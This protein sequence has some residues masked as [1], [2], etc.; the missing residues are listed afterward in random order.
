MRPT[1]T[2]TTA[3]VT[4]TPTPRP[5]STPTATSSPEPEPIA[6]EGGQS[7]GDARAPELGNTGYD[8]QSYLLALTV[9]PDEQSIHGT[10]T[11]EAVATLAHLGRL[12]LDFIG[13]EIEHL[14]VDGVEAPFQRHDNKLIVDLPRPLGLGETF[15][16]AVTYGGQPQ[17]WPSPY[18]SFIPLG[19]HFT[20]DAIYAMA[21]PDG[22]RTWFPC[23][24]HPRDKA[25]FRYEITVPQG[26]VVA[27]NGLPQ[28]TIDGESTTTFW[29]QHGSPMATYLATIAVGHFQIIEGTA[30]SGIPLWHYV[31]AELLAPAQ[32][33]LGRTG[34]MIGFLESFF[35]PYP[36]ESYGHAVVP[37]N[38]VSMETQTLTL[39]DAGVVSSGAEW[40]MVHELAHQWFGDSVGPASWSDIWLNEGFAVY[41]SWLWAEAHSPDDL[42]WQLDA[43]EAQAPNADP[44]EPLADP[45]ADQLFG[46]NSYIKGA[47]VL[48]MLQHQIGD[49]LFFDVLRAYHE[50][51]EGGVASTDDLKTIV[52]EISGQELDW[53][54]EQWVYGT[55]MPEL[56]VN[57]QQLPDN[58]LSV[59]ICQR[60]PAP[61]L[62]P[63]SLLSTDQSANSAVE[64]IVVDQVD[65]RFSWSLPFAAQSVQVDPQQHLLA[66]VTVQ[67]AEVFVDCP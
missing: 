1:P 62:F 44:G 45:S 2:G 31:P 33:L 56:I 65:E 4:P 23:N 9:E 35:G 13:L 10:T 38:G 26:Y 50:R 51:F 37:M 16:I 32:E 22:A 42:R 29:W 34:E 15:Y 55:G 20:Q 24:D 61:F 5:S 59:Q 43:A 27:A 7:I 30:A 57:W 49:E 12:S 67:Q 46:F 39:L 64:T 3:S 18:L 47:W 52:E 58:T 36:F 63:L 8:V 17:L 40:V 54:F 11:I 28:A 19:L 48:R 25:L 6:Q 60:Q 53:F 21:E 41:A 14:T 66:Q